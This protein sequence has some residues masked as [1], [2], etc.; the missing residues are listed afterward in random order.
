M[1]QLPLGILLP[2]SCELESISHLASTGLRS[3]LAHAW[4]Q[5]LSPTPLSALTLLFLQISRSRIPFS[6]TSF[7]TSS[8]P[9]SEASSGILSHNLFVRWGCC[10][11]VTATVLPKTA[12]VCSFNPRG[13]RFEVTVVPGP[14]SLCSLQGGRLC[15]SPGFWC[16]WPVLASL[17]LF[18]QVA[19]LH[20]SSRSLSLCLRTSRLHAHLP[21]HLFF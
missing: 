9:P 4:K 16:C 20:L 15:L 5:T 14:H 19:S 13:Y 1:A 10:N 3:T 7:L 17:G 21:L 6:G 18:L 11:K 8:L 2:P 12:E